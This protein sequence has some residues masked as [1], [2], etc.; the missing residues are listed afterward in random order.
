MHP[1]YKNVS[2]VIVPVLFGQNQM[3]YLALHPTEIKEN[4]FNQHIVDFVTILKLNYH[5]Y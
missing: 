3:I 4:F 1:R 2:P 5:K